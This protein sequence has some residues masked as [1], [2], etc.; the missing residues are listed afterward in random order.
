MIRTTASIQH[1]CMLAG[2]PV[3]CAIH[4]A[5]R[6]STSKQ[7]HI[8]TYLT[9]LAPR[10]SKQTY[11]DAYFLLL[12]ELAPSQT[13]SHTARRVEH[14]PTSQPILLHTDGN[15]FRPGRSVSTA[16][17][18]LCFSWRSGARSEALHSDTNCF[19]DQ[20]FTP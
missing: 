14:D 19:R 1:H 4:D 5:S 8:Q 9:K 11:E 3:G 16:R 7:G 2:F 18:I 13:T 17:N 12:M 20:L 15:G 10:F 6:K